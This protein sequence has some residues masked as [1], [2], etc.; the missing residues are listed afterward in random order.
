MVVEVTKAYQVS[1][2]RR[3]IFVPVM[4]I[5]MLTQMLPSVALAFDSSHWA[6]KWLSE[7]QV[8]EIVKGYPD[9]S[10]QPDRPVTRAEFC[11]ILIRLMKEEAAAQSGLRLPSHFVDVGPNYWGKGY[12]EIAYEKGI[13]LGEDGGKAWP[14]RSI[15]RAEAVTMVDR[16]AAI[17]GVPMSATSGRSFLDSNR[18]PQWARLAVQRLSGAKVVEGDSDGRFY[19]DRNLTRAEAAAL[20]IRCLD[21]AGSRWDLTG[22]IVKI[23]PKGELTLD[24]QGEE[25]RFP[26]SVLK[27]QVFLENDEIAFNS[28]R[29]GQNIG[30]V[31]SQGAVAIISVL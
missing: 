29:A 2:S 22:R 1:A 25:V 12:L 20:A 13:F 31:F 4:V 17:L 28:L 16:C 18:I 27:V 23:D 19:P 11:T 30:L 3:R 9:G 6:H 8:R 26:V 7:S 14:D 15:T 5:L 10:V 21:L 24:I